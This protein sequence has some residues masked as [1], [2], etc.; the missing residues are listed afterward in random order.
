MNYEIKLHES[1]T[2]HFQWN[3]SRPIV[4]RVLEEKYILPKECVVEQVEEMLDVPKKRI[5][6]PRDLDYSLR[7]VL[8]EKEERDFIERNNKLYDFWKK[9]KLLIEEW[10]V[11][12]GERVNSNFKHFTIDLDEFGW[13][14]HELDTQE[15]QDTSYLEIS[16]I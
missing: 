14:S 15:D 12:Y 13:N 4:K 1:G 7:Q 2:C 8:S 10:I 6:D 16:A 3:D 9:A 11:L 5:E